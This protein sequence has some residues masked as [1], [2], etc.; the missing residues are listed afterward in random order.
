MTSRKSQT[1]SIGL[2]STL[3][4]SLIGCADDHGDSDNRPQCVREDNGQFIIVEER[5]CPTID[6]DRDDDDVHAPIFWYY[7]GSGG[8]LPG[9]VAHGGSWN[10]NSTVTPPKTSKSGGEVKSGHIGGGTAGKSSSGVG[11]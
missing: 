11:G 4:I 2:V 10:R 8:H 9:A 5:L 1:V 3:A 7:G 6:E